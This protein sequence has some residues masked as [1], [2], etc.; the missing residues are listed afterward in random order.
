MSLLDVKISRI[1]FEL[2]QKYR[3]LDKINFKRA[4]EA[5]GL[6]VLLV[7]RGEISVIVGKGGKTIRKLT[8]SIHT[9]VRVAEEGA[10]IRKQAQDIFTPAKIHGVNILYS[11]GGE[12]YRIRIPR[13]HLKLLPASIDALQALFAKLTDKNIKI[14]FE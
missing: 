13:A 12:E 8:E 14:V 9:K 1:L 4:I 3:G 7:R 5:K 10:D 11:G 2:A 6:I